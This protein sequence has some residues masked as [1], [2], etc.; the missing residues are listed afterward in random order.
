MT[1][2]VAGQLPADKPRYLMGVGTPVDLIEAVRRGVDMFDCILPTKMAQQGWAYTFEGLLRVT[3]DVFRLD[4]AP[5]EEGCDCPT[6]GRY[7]RAYLNHLM[8]GKHRLGSR[9][10]SVHNLRHYQRLMARL[11]A[12]I[13]A[14]RFEAE[15][16]ALL[17]RLDVP[18]AIAAAD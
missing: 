10:L 3:R 13:L 4:E 1:A 8:R 15:A 17:E 12:A 9:F 2:R 5:L 6:C 14:G 18:K 16:R 7:S 11:R